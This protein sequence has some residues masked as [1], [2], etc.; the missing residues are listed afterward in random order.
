MPTP[1]F[2]STT[3]EQYAEDPSHI[4]WDGVDEFYG[5]GN[6]EFSNLRS[7]TD[8]LH[9]SDPTVND[10]KMKTWYLVASGFN[11]TNVPATISGLEVKLIA[12]RHGRITDDTV[13]IR[14]NGDIIGANKANAGLDAE[15]IYGGQTDD[16]GNYG[17]DRS[18][19]LMPSFGILLR[20]QSHPNWPHR[21]PVSVNSVSIRIW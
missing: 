5:F 17:I 4:K 7:A 10:I 12:K 6:P 9:I 15:K 3:V 13:Q 19:F 2:L 1:W 20:F 21:A 14:V 18:M 11:P 8:L 16:W